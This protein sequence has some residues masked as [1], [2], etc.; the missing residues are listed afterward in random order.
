MELI[1]DA[2]ERLKAGDWNGA[3]VIAQDDESPTGAWLHGVVH[4][5]EGDESNARYW[6]R[7][8]GRPFP[9]MDAVESEMAAIR[10]AIASAG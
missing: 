4:I 7:R 10:D 1:L 3:H 5:V 6:Y 8:A 9:G 2:L